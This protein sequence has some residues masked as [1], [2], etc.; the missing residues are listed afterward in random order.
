AV[1]PVLGHYLAVLVQRPTVRV[2]RV[3]RSHAC[4]TSCHALSSSHEK[5]GPPASRDPL[6]CLLLQSVSLA[7]LVLTDDV[8]ELADRNPILTL[9]LDADIVLS[10]ENHRRK[11]HAAHRNMAGVHA[12]LFQQERHKVCAT[13]GL[14]THSIL[15][16]TKNHSQGSCNSRPAPRPRRPSTSGGSTR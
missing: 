14:V 6:S 4:P 16:S 1:N 5:R 11:R 3:L 10:S 7:K 15:L 12:E 8:V 9:P 2:E 13:L